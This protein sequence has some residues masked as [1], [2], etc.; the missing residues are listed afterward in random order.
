M[1]FWQN[2]VDLNGHIPAVWFPAFY[3][4]NQ[5]LNALI[6][7]VARSQ[8][9]PTS[10]LFTRFEIMDIYEPI[11]ENCPHESNSAYAYGLWL[12]GACWDPKK[13]MLVEPKNPNVY[14]R[15]PIVKIV[16]DFVDG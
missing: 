5:F 16:A 1:K 2:L 9:V 12:E 15:F 6:Q 11:P 3:D 7:K 14:N 10:A 8:D 13:R 4:P